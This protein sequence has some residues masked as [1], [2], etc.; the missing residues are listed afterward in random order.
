MTSMRAIVQRVTQASV[1][2]EG[3]T[4]GAIDQPGLCVLLGVTHSDG[5]AQ[6]Q[7]MASKI[8]NLRILRGERSALNVGAPLLVISQ[9]TLYGDTRQGRRPS[10]SAAAP[11]QHA[12]PLVETVIEQLRSLGLSV[13][14]GI[15]GASMQVSLTN[16]GPFTV[17][18]EVG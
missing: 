10:W 9:F 5:L 11:S 6:A 16:D 15:F 13:S 12:Q 8:A 2:V 18:V 4:V 3:A 1:S 14:T 7:A 17:T